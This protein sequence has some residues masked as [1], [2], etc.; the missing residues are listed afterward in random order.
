MPGDYKFG[1]L[2]DKLLRLCKARNPDYEKIKSVIAE[3]ADVNKTNVTGDSILYCCTHFASHGGESFAKL[4]EIFVQSGF[5]VKNKGLGV[6]GGLVHSTYNRHIFD[7]AKILLMSGAAGDEKRWK[8]ILGSIGGEESYQRC[9]DG[10]HSIENVYYDFYELVDAARLNKPI[11]GIHVWPDA[12]GCTIDKV[13]ACGNI[14]G[15][16]VGGKVAFDGAIVFRSGEK[17]IVISGTPNICVFGETFLDGKN[18]C[19]TRRSL[20]SRA[21]HKIVDITFEHKEVTKDT[22]SY[23]Q[24]NIYLHFEDGIAV[25]FSTNF[26]EVEEDE[27]T[28][29]YEMV[30]IGTTDIQSNRNTLLS[31]CKSENS[32][33]NWD[34]AQIALDSGIDINE[35]LPDTYGYQTTY[36]MAAVENSN[37]E[38]ARFLV[39]RGADPNLIVEDDSPLNALRFYEENAEENRE[40][41][42]ITELLLEHGADPNLNVEGEPICASAFYYD[43]YNFDIP[44]EYSTYRSEYLVI[45]FKYGGKT[46]QEIDETE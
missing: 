25:R 34:A 32:K 33:F 39:E 29:Y 30:D 44:E 15:E 23:R 2:E 46:Y 20:T 45:L 14:A 13:L 40:R 12:V 6:I 5:D 26:G 38:A 17:Y 9:C 4:A 24:P 41:L 19:E 1:K 3:G 37:Y 10:N 18:I 21:G 31:L 28:N 8:D 11:D 35:I 7:A 16:P 43:M 42:R 36:L 27:T 22:A